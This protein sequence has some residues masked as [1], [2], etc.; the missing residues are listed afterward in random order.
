MLRQLRCLLLNLVK[1]LVIYGKDYLLTILLTTLYPGFTLRVLFIPEKLTVA[2]GQSSLPYCCEQASH[3]VPSASVLRQSDPGSTRNFDIIWANRVK[4]SPI[5][6]QDSLPR[7]HHTLS[8]SSHH[9]HRGA[10][11]F[12]ASS[13]SS[14][15]SS[16]HVVEIHSTN[17]SDTSSRWGNSLGK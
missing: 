7:G 10:S 13:N 16:T 15:I 5:M 8:A 6:F 9:L 4:T 14:G 17:G 2:A 3:I 11:S 12:D 1:Q